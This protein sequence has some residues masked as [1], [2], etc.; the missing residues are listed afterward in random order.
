MAGESGARRVDIGFTG[1]QVLSLRMRESDYEGLRTAVEDGKSEG[2]QTVHTED[3]E[4][5]IDMAQVVY[6][7]VDTDQHKVGF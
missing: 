3:S 6:V 4:V 2:W 5:R 1:G 7:R